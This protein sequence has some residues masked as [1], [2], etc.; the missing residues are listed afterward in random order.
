MSQAPNNLKEWALLVYMCADVPEPAMH[1]SSHANLLQMADIGSSNDVAVV[2]QLA[3]PGPWT[4]RYIFPPRPAGSGPSTVKPVHALP[5]VNS[6]VPGS[7][8]DFFA[9]ATETCPAKNT[10]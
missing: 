8:Q 2:A 7:I 10:M 4:Y 6:G 3:N 5:S 1:Q 9:W